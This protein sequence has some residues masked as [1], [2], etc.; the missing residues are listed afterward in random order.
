MHMWITFAIIGVAVFLFVSEWIELELV[1]L[2]VIAALLL[3]FQLM[4]LTGADGGNLL[5][6]DILLSG[7][8][9]TAL[10]TILA[11][12]VVGQGLHYS[13]ALDGVTQLLST[14]RRSRARILI[15]MCLIGAGIM[16]AFL[17]NTPVVVMFIPVIA[18][19]ANRYGPGAGRMLLPLS[20]I[21][22]LGG[23]VTLVGSSTNLLVAG[24]VE[25]TTDLKMGFFDLFMPGVILACVGALY[26]LFV[27]PRLLSHDFEHSGKKKDFR[28]GVQ[29]LARIEVHPQHKLFGETG[30]KKTFASL[31]DVTVRF[32]KRHG[33]M[34]YPPYDNV[35][36]R[37]RDI[38]QFAGT[39]A[40]VS[41][42]LD[43]NPDGEHLFLA[44]AAI[45]PASRLGGR[46]IVD[47]EFTE[48]TGCYI[49]GIQRHKR[50][51]RDVRNKIRLRP[52]DV[53][54]IAGT[55]DN[56]R[57]L[58][59]DRDLM[60]L[61]GSVTTIHAF[62]KAN[63]AL[64]IFAAVVLAAA[65]GL[66]PIVISS[67]AG[68]LLMMLTGCLNIA[69]A[70]RAIDRRIVLLIAASI[71]M[72]AALE[73]TGGAAF[74]AHSLVGQLAGFGPTIT[75]SALFLL[76]AILTNLLSNSATALLFTP[77][78][79][80]MATSL[81]VSTVAFVHAVI[82]AANCSFAS[83]L[84]YQTNLLVMRPGNYRFA[85]YFRAGGPL[86]ILIWVVFSLIAPW[87]Y[88]LG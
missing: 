82:F 18:A 19:L 5:S 45:A 86:V 37:D 79:I 60:V 28:S 22:I 7:F 65:T 81:D 3:L 6:P 29:F 88:G 58:R 75:L 72:A 73:K 77:I 61:E 38:V 1:S 2:G 52:G 68:A 63:L 35:T 34:K 13:G 71:A 42:L 84:G 33:M 27:V 57:K 50:M 9:N 10:L 80:S 25:K 39:R 8:S 40:Q 43:L 24:L 70:A 74:I 12:L 83:P 46:N 31:K 51:K 66:V 85:D 64:G 55:R 69:Q 54:L 41:E 78:A 53:F 59:L 26:V 87:Y 30:Q 49:V 21:S 17:N 23:M 47:E 56:I 14:A 36:L 48:Q 11:L 76:V 67:I 32:V 62:T 16:S 44:E 20:Y 4:P 15:L